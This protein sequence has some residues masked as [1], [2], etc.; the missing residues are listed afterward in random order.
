MYKFAAASPQ[1]TI[2]FG[3][4]RPGYSDRQINKWL[5]FM[6]NQGIQQVCCL[7]SATQLHRYPNLIDIYQQNFGED[8]VCWSPI[9]D[10]SLVDRST[11]LQQ[12]L[13]FLLI[14]HQQ[15]EKVVVHCSGGSGRTGHILAAWLV[16]K[17]GLSNQESIATVRHTGRNPD[18]A[19]VA[20]IFKGRHPWRVRAELQLLL[21][22]CRST[23]SSVD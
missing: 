4:A 5:E 20:A 3:A 7:L 1:E 11:L 6:K 22:E 21:N 23:T 18:E 13:P 2:V 15:N 8:R 16:T 10:F 17:Y 9:V 14:A 19:V 12:I